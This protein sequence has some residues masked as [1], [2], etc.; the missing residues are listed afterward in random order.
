MNKLLK[1]MSLKE[2]IGQM[3]QLSPFFLIAELEKE[4]AG[5]IR[6]LQIDQTKIFSIG[7]ILGIK[8]AS[9]M[10]AVQKRYLEKSRLGIPLIFMGDVIHGYKTIFP[11][12]IAIA[13]SWAPELAYCAASIS[14]KEASV[15]GLHMTFSPM[16]DLVRDPRWGR[17]VESFGESPKM[18]GEFSKAMV[19]GYQDNGLYSCVKHYAAYGAAEGG[20]DYNTVHLSQTDLYNYYLEGYRQ[21]VQ[22]GCKAVMTAFNTWDGIPCTVHTFLLR[23]VLR[24]QLGFRGVILSDYAS[25]QEVITHGVAKNQRDAAKLGVE[26]GLDLEMATVCYLNNLEDLVQSGEVD[27]QQIEASLERL[28]DLKKTIG[29]LENPFLNADPSQE[30]ERIRHPDHLK[31]SRRVAEESVILLKNNGIC[32]L[33]PEMTVAIMG[34]FANS[35]STNGPWSWHG[36]QDQNKSL[37]EV[38]AERKIKISG[39]NDTL[40]LAR[41]SPSEKDRL[42][43]ADVF[44]LLL[45]ETSTRS[46][47]AHSLSLLTLSPEQ[48]ALYQEIKSW[49]K[50]IVVL[51]QN[52]RPLVLGAILDADAILETWFL[53]SMAND[54]IADIL[55][56]YVNPSGKCPMSFPRSEG[57]IP[58]Y[59]DH[60]PT[61][62]PNIDDRHPGEYVSRYL[63]NL[64]SP[65]FEFGY[66]LSYSK[67]S[68]INLRLSQKTLQANETL[69]VSVDLINQGPFPGQEVVQ[70]YF[71]DSVAK[72]SRPVKQ[73][74]RFQ[75]VSLKVGEKK[76]IHF[77]LN[78]EDFSYY[79]SDGSRT[80]D[81]GQIILFAGSDPQHL[82]QTEFSLV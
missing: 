42:K 68:T 21:A 74:V 4:A 14:A 22:A 27:K 64:N 29:L 63:D 26:A 1:K 39:I 8:D 10:I 33:K 46:G 45:G 48:I 43:T 79:L 9:E 56:G 58:V 61:G 52:G 38:L 72:I 57:Q 19:K 2:M 71:F 16:A 82:L 6:E 12:P 37:P 24:K 81:P 54:A 15:S 76:T 70:L 44:L 53:G 51:L 20:R 3:S 36:S 17:V 32:P 50:P 34:P 28:I 41:I 77:E 31:A 40:D 5:P 18:V 30:K 69:E 66:G 73:L 7:S 60:L 35:G 13:S 75:K 23:D 55:F 59:H 11:V 62:R 65:Q 49:N 80:M 47:E 25:L 78:P 67:F